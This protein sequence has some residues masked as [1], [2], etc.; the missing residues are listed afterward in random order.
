MTELN[1]L[2]QDKN[3]E[4]V[5]FRQIKKKKAKLVSNLQPVRKI[6]NMHVRTSVIERFSFKHCTWR[7]I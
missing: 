5:Q 1:L 6:L 2:Q 4:V 3:K 7:P